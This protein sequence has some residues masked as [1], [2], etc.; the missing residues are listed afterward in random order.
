MNLLKNDT[1]LCTKKRLFLLI[2]ILSLLVVVGVII[3]I[4]F[5][6]PYNGV[7]EW[8]KYSDNPRSSF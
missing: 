4:L 2:P 6:D 1:I 7:L 8:S 5:R 3:C